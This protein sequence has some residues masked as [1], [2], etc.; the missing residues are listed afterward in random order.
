MEKNSTVEFEV[1]FQE[2]SGGLEARSPNKKIKKK[3]KGKRPP[4]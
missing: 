2:R 1:A 4:M 3:K